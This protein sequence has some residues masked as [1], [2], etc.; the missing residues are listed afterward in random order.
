V[1][2]EV[3]KTAKVTARLYRLQ[4]EELGNF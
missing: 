2:D 1:V 4:L 3:I